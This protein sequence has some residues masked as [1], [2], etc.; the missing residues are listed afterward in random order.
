MSKEEL[1]ASPVLL[2][3]PAAMISCADA[4][5]RPN[6]ITLAWVGVVCSEP[7][8]LGIG[9]RPNRHSHQMIVESGE[10]VVNIP[11]INQV[12]ETDYCGLVS[13]RDTDKFAATGLTPAPGKWTKAPII[14]ECPVNVECRLRQVVELG[15]HDLFIGEVVGVQADAGTIGDNG[16]PDV[17]K[18]RP[19]AYAAGEYWSLGSEVAPRGIGKK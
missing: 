4:Q 6:I 12:K 13:G 7:P 14:E 1:R 11:S 9:V 3:V 16:R 19:L 18:I 8:M 17:S 5:G 2:P 10:F 15:S